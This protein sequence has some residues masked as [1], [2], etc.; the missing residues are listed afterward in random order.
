LA[1]VLAVAEF[2]A[3]WLAEAQSVAGDQLA[4]VAL[5]ILVYQQTNHSAFWAAAVYALTFLPALA[6]G[7]GLAQLADRY[8]RRPL[9][10]SCALIQ[11]ALVGAMAIPGMPIAALCVLV[12]GVQL[13]QSPAQAAQNA[14]TRE[15]FTDDELYLRSQDLRGITTNVLMLVG[16][17]GGGLLVMGIGTSASLAIDAVTFLA[18]ALLIGRYV[19]NRPA[20]GD[21][22]DG[23]FGAARWVFKDVRLRLLVTMAWLVGLIVV[24]EGLAAPLAR[25]LGAPDAAVGWVLAAD[26]LGFVV[27]TFVLS[28]W[29]GPDT[30]VRVMGVLATC[31]AATLIAFAAHPGLP[32][33]LV[34]LALAGA[35]GAYQIT[36]SATF[37]TLVPNAI[38]GGAIGVAATGLR[39]A[40][41]LGVA[42]GG[43]VAELTGSATLTIALAGAIAV[44][45]AVPTAV[46]WARVPAKT[47][48]RPRHAQTN[49]QPVGPPHI[50]RV[51]MEADSV[52]E[53]R[54][55]PAARG[56]RR[57]PGSR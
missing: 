14:A 11:A 9:M 56:S 19:R 12:V 10:V 16:L 22:S 57:L 15:I 18:S 42:A 39:V 33:V 6:G 43:A 53:P 4:K 52:T 44:L 29:V 25:E 34:L 2:R 26:P 45:I 35:L 40:Q 48:R 32:L 13:A 50:P 27:G 36:V 8:P 46:A 7:L 30:R 20:A 1:A 47:G 3:L 31:S 37:N 23:W 41:G 54:P 51:R 55:R 5:V 38:R 49:G 24:P 28:R 21:R 17:A